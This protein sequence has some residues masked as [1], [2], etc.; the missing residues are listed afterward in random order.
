[1]VGSGVESIRDLHGRIVELSDLGVGL[2]VG[3]FAEAVGELQ[4]CVNSL[5]EVHRRAVAAAATSGEWALDGFRS[6]SRW[7]QHHTG[8]RASRAAALSTQ[9]VEMSAMPHASAAALGGAIGEVHV[10]QLVHCR[11]RAPHRFD[12]ETERAFTELAAAGDLAQFALAVRTWIQATE[13][14]DAPDPADLPVE[15]QQQ[16]LRYGQ[17]LDGWLRGE[18]LLDPSN[19]AFFAECIERGVTARIAERRAEADPSSDPLRLASVRAGVLIDLLDQGRRRNPATAAAPDRHTVALALHLDEHGH[20]RPVDPMPPGAT[21]DATV[22][23][24]VLDADGMPLDIGRASRTWP[25][26]LRAAIIR[27]DEHCRFPGCDAPPS[28]CDVHHCTPWELGGGT[29][30]QNGVLLCRHHHTFLHSKRWTVLLGCRRRPV[31]LRRDGTEFQLRCH[32]PRRPTS[33]PP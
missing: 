24:L 15:E 1:M 26:P 11:R 25:A 2:C 16:E 4:R 8:L 3:E 10:E 14:L 17:T 9:A 22:F 13:A 20:V 21:C 18:F 27:R 33:D 31:F 30:L 12:A 6:P 19:A 23:R 29:S 28:H 7:V 32:A 5:A